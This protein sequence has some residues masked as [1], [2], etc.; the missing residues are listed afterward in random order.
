MKKKN[1]LWPN[2]IFLDFQLPKLYLFHFVAIEYFKLFL[3]KFKS[4]LLAIHVEIKHV[5]YDTFNFNLWCL[6][7]LKTIQNSTW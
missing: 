2:F 7:N 1:C 5:L 3:L 6:D 4:V